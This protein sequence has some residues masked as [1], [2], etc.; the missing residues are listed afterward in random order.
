MAVNLF[1]DTDGTLSDALESQTQTQIDGNREVRNIGNIF[2]SHFVE[3]V[4]R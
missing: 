2:D 4:R 1:L 3:F